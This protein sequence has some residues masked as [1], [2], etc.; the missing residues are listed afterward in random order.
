MADLK[1][2]KYCIAAKILWNRSRFSKTLITLYTLPN[3]KISD[4]LKSWNSFWMYPP[5]WTSLL[6]VM[7]DDIENTSIAH[8]N[9]N[10]SDD[11]G[12][13]W[14]NTSPSTPYWQKIIYYQI[15]V[16]WKSVLRNQFLSRTQCF[17]RLWEGILLNSRFFQNEVWK[18]NDFLT[19][20]MKTNK[21]GLK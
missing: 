5:L 11:N 14:S 9:E 6:V 7:H 12:Q 20:A 19:E 13:I 16:R 18:I 10:T 3:H 1:S 4:E 15:V 2:L 17:R 21:Q 8:K